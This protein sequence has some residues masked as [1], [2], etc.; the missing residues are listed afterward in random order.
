MR[1]KIAIVT[2]FLFS[3]I[4]LCSL[5]YYLGIGFGNAVVKTVKGVKEYEKELVME[6][7]NPL[8]SIKNQITKI[9]DTA[10]V[11]KD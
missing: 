4:F 6:D 7:V 2:V 11:K 8:D 9:I 10:E 5:Y 1:N 3:L